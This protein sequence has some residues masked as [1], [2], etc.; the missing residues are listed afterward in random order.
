MTGIGAPNGKHAHTLLIRD[1][2]VIAEALRR[3]LDEASPENRPGL[4]HALALVASAAATTETQLRARWVRSRLAAVGFAGDI[5]SIAALKALR[6]AEPRLGL[7]EAVGLQKE[8][9]AHPE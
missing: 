7:A 3:A 1:A 5:A 8:A 6:K 9:V 2:D 4:E